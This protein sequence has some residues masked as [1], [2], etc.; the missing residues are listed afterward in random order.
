MFYNPSLSWGVIRV[1]IYWLGYPITLVLLLVCCLFLYLH[2]SRH[3][4]FIC[5]ITSVKMAWIVINYDYCFVLTTTLTYGKK[6]GHCNEHE[7]LPKCDFLDHPE[8]WGFLLAVTVADEFLPSIYRQSWHQSSWTWLH[9]VT[10]ACRTCCLMACL[11]LFP[12][13]FFWLDAFQSSLLR[14]K[15]KNFKL[16]HIPF[17][18]LRLIFICD[19]FFTK[20]WLHFV[21]F[22]V[23]G[24]FRRSR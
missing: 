3:F 4:F 16:L 2:L 21:L 6:N 8:L 1:L 22:Q 20:D 19:L 7:F 23:T 14:N 12:F 18:T 15:E 24:F 17:P 9:M 11:D 13:F 10:L 5:C